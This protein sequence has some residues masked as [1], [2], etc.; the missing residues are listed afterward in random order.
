MAKDLG[1]VAHYFLSSAKVKGGCTLKVCPVISIASVIPDIPPSFLTWNLALSITKAG[2]IVLVLDSERRLPTIN[3]FMGAKSGTSYQGPLG[4]RVLTAPFDLRYI[5][6]LKE[7]ERAYLF[8]GLKEVEERADIILINLPLRLTKDSIELASASSDEFL[9]FISPE[10][11]IIT[12]N[13]GVLSALEGKKMTI[14]PFLFQ[15]GEVEESIYYRIPW[16][17]IHPASVTAGS[18][19]KATRLILEMGYLHTPS[20][21]APLSEKI[22]NRAE[23]GKPSA[24]SQ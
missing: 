10:N 20:A 7:G 16:C 9:V 4:I 18:I 1:D 8:D 19:A 13:W 3:F 23:G 21:K 5:A 2:K 6:G 24:Y 14:S 15:Q 12:E 22:R 17:L 11:G